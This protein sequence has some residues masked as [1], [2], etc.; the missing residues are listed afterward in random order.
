LCRMTLNR[1]IRIAVADDHTILRDGICQILGATPGIEVIAQVGTGAEAIKLADSSDLDCLL[2]DITLPDRDGIEVIKA[3]RRNNKKLP[4]L[5]LSMHPEEQYAIRSLKAGASGYIGKTAS[6][7]ELLMAIRQVSSNVKFI[8]PI[9][10][11]LL[12]DR[13]GETIHEE[14]HTTLSDREYQFLI[15]VAMGFTVTEIADQMAISVKTVSMYRSRTL[16]KMNMKKNAQLA[17]YAIKQNLV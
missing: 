6:I 4:I 13:V 17:Q 14:P 5:M 8:S 9:V 3:V 16:K 7:K 15:K 11:D 12:A 2:L 1:L 10:A